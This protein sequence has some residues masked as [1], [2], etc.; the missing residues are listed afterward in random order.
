M[1]DRSRAGLPGVL[2]VLTAMLIAACGGGATATATPTPVAPGETTPTPAAE[3]TPTP[4]GS[5]RRSDAGARAP[6]FDLEALTG[7]LPGR[8]SH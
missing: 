1:F 7:G 2:L 5:G 4:E 8:L 3:A 6:N